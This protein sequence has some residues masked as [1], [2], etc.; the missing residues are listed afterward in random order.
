MSAYW[1]DRGAHPV[2]VRPSQEPDILEDDIVSLA[3]PDDSHSVH[4]ACASEYAARGLALL[5]DHSISG[6]QATAAYLHLRTQRKPMWLVE[7]SIISGWR[8]AGR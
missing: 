4:E 6:L 7:V 2:R 8:A 5:S 3:K 1:F